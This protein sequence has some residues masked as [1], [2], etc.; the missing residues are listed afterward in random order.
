MKF[1]YNFIFW[2]AIALIDW[3]GLSIADAAAEDISAGSYLVGQFAR[4]N[5]NVDAAIDSLRRIHK[6]EP[7][8]ADITSQLQ[9]MLLLK[10]NVE[11]A[12]V[13]AS[14]IRQTD[15]KDQLS[16][17]LLALR[18]VKGNNPVGAAAMLDS[19]FQNGNAQLWL[20]LISAWLDVSR[21]KLSKPLTVEALGADV[22][23]AAPLVNYHLALINAQA[24]FTDAAANNFKNAVTDPR[25]PPMRVMRMLLQFY[26]QNNSPEVLTPIV[27]AFH[28]SHPDDKDD[29]DVSAVTN[30][31][32]GIA[33]VLYTMGGIMLGAEAN[34]DAAIY[35]QMALYIKPDFADAA[36]A[37]G[38]AYGELQQY[39]R[40][41]EAYGRIAA[42]SSLHEQAQLHIVVNYDRMD[43]LSDALV[44]LDTMAK[45]SPDNPDALITKGDLLRVHSRYRDAV[46]AYSEAL[47][48]VREPKNKY[49]PVWFARGTCFE[50]LGNW[51]AAESDLQQALVLKPDQPDV[52]NYLGYGQMERSENLADARV[53]IEKAVK[54]RPDDAEIVDSMGWALYLSGDYQKATEYLEK[55]VE[56]LPGDAT[57]NDH[58]GDV[59]WRLGHKTEA[60]YQWE[61]SLNSSPEAKEADALHRKL[62]EGLPP[63]AAMADTK[64]VSAA[65]P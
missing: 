6:E 57:V 49:W 19:A 16:D 10:G 1:Q 48:R 34:N 13:M 28:D 8:N 15:D 63:P 50:R 7:D 2:L 9:G 51:K 37:L 32:D 23:R 40:S 20:P 46:D 26:K 25:N 64:P 44:T 54:A 17:L 39:A 62:K 27:T 21:N 42:N 14:D 61:R 36:L 22:G 59:Y 4:N 65:T 11:E 58:L 47:S 5:G 55:A 43:K 45:Q 35:L 29:S 41:N 33:E 3:V 52:L 31:H 56:L 18:E 30:A 24:G 12:I 38:D 53:M 60:R